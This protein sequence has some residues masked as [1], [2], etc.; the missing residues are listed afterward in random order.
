MIQKSIDLISNKWKDLKVIYGDTD[1]LFILAKNMKTKKC[2][3]LAQKIVKEINLIFP[4]PIKIK[5][6]KV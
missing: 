4:Q 2:F 6:E 5:F 1:S 3:E